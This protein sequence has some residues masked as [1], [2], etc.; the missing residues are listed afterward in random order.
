MGLG[1]LPSMVAS[2]ALLSPPSLDGPE[3]GEEQVPAPGSH[4]LGTLSEYLGAPGVPA[5]ASRTWGAS[6]PADL[7]LLLR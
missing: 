4:H 6:F 3:P 2:Q 5:S 1:A 7:V